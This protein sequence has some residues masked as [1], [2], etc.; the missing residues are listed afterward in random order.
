MRNLESCARPSSRI[1]R[2]A[3]IEGPING[4]LRR[5]P[6]RS[7]D[8]KSGRVEVR[9]G[10]QE[11]LEVRK[12]R[13]KSSAQ[14]SREPRVSVYQKGARASWGRRDWLRELANSG[15]IGFMAWRFEPSHRLHSSSRT[16][17]SG[18]IVSAHLARHPS[19]TRREVHQKEEIEQGHVILQLYASTSK[20]CRSYCCA[21]GGSS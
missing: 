8:V 6:A 1:E 7:R 15:T 9:T 18:R 13:M 3:K 5:K 2:T 17:I 10:E 14:V 21:E 20:T 11:V 12:M 16:R 4:G 19:Q